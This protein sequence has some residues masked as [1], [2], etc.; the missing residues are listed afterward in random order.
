MKVVSFL[1]LWWN[2]CHASFSLGFNITECVVESTGVSQP[3]SISSSGDD[4]NGFLER[5]SLSQNPAMRAKALKAQKI[6]EGISSA[7]DTHAVEMRTG[8]GEEDINIIPSGGGQ[9]IVFFGFI[10]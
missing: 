3:F 8:E 6:L 9:G 10:Q 7:D 5:M 2:V 4:V 1:V